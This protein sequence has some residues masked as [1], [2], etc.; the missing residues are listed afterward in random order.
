MVH[1][2]ASPIYQGC[3]VS[4]N[5]KSVLAFFNINLACLNFDLLLKTDVLASMPVPPLH[6]G[7]LMLALINQ[8]LELKI[9]TRILTK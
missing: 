9:V 5:D 7:L 6:R 8:K 2:G 3:Q 1:L 4:E